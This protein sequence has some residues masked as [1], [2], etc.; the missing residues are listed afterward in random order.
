MAEATETKRER[1]HLRLDTKSKRKLERAAAYE[2]TTVSRFVLHNAVTAA[3]R[4][5]EAHERNVL[6]ATDW[7]AFHDALLN[8]PEPNAVL[9]RAARRYRERMGG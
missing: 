2:E 8:P 9:R 1:V 3:E 4:V 5:I 6:P 7:N